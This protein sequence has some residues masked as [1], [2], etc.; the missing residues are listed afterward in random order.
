MIPFVDLN[1]LHKSIKSEIDDAIQRVIAQSDFI[2]GKAVNEFEA[3][4]AKYCEVK[5]AAG[6]SSGTA[7]LF[8]ALK[9]L[10][11]GHGDEVIV[12]AHTFIATAMAVSQCGAKPVF[13]DVDA[14]TW[15][16]TS[17]QIQAAITPKTKAVIAVH[18]Y[19]LPAPMQEIA[20]CCR[21]NNL[22]LIED[23]A[24]AH[25][26]T[27]NGKRLG[28]FGDAACFSFYPSKNLG[29][30]GEGGAVV[31]DNEALISKVKMLRDYGRTDKYA[32][33][34]LGY[35]LRLQGMQAAVLSVKLPH[36][37]NWNAERKNNAALYKK[38]LTDSG[39]QFQFIPE[40]YESVYHLMVIQSEH[41]KQIIQALEA[42]Q[43]GYGIHYPIP[44]HL[45]DAYKKLGYQKGD[46]P[47]SE[48]LAEQCISLPMYVGMG[49]E[50]VISVA[51]KLRQFDFA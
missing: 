31:S 47:V 23:A 38:L 16:I 30:M 7:A 10:G 9:A 37:D 8:L 32:H 40:G 48:G 17:A 45:Q 2:V 20:E 27:L 49:E 34:E 42:A 11:I 50:R 35:N 43:I 41:R 26:A 15:N 13:V 14:S 24:Q 1:P 21:E 29:A 4:F 19:G 5:F 33:A 51:E 36:L 28:S 12:P 25:G 3:S 39:L 18:I 6:V 46:L 22:F 44:C